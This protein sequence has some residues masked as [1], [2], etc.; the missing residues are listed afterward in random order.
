MTKLTNE[1]PND[2][3]RQR[4]FRVFFVA[5]GQQSED[6]SHGST[7]CREAK[8]ELPQIIFSNFFI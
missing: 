4:E 7:G 5:I 1:V 6:Q 3:N 2:H 8:S